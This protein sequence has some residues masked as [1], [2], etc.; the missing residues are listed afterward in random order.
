[1][2]DLLSTTLASF[3]LASSAFAK[4]VVNN[5]EV[6]DSN[7]HYLKYARYVIVPSNWEEEYDP[8][9]GDQWKLAD[10][11]VAAI[12]ADTPPDEEEIAQLVN[13]FKLSYPNQ[14]GRN[15]IYSAMKNST[16][17][18]SFESPQ[19]ARAVAIQRF[20]TVRMMVRFNDDG[21]YKYFNADNPPGTSAPNWEPGSSGRRSLF[22]QRRG[23]AFESITQITA[24][25]KTHSTAEAWKTRAN[26]EPL[27]NPTFGECMGAAIACIWWGA[28]RGMGENAFNGLYPGPKA[29]N[30]DD[31]DDNTTPSQR[32]TTLTDDKTLVPGDWVYFQNHNYS[33]VKSKGDLF[34]SLN[35]AYGKAL[36]VKKIYYMAGENALYVGKDSEGKRKFDG[37]GFSDMTELQVREKLA[38]SYNE[39]FKGVID[40]AAKHGGVLPVHKLIVKY[41]DPDDPDV[42]EA[43]IPMIL[44]R[45][46]KR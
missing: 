35:P 42:L 13:S 26:V 30:M 36:L 6:T 9:Q 20:E 12:E 23:S 43:K 21:R 24:P 16:E 37:L 14:N 27:Q 40:E 32:N 3:F 25:L 45:R 38:W 17:V 1:M 7:E 10:S 46:L 18:F 19:H 5:V 11:F 31:K 22:R 34:D 2:R 33:E 39:D 41:I 29:L 8:T 15:E 28:S 4:I 44:I